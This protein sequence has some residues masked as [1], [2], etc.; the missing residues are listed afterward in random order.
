[1]FV[2]DVLKLEDA[3]V[4]TEFGYRNARVKYIS[5]CHEYVDQELSC[6]KA[7]GSGVLNLCYVAAGRLDVCYAGVAG[8]HATGPLQ[9]FFVRG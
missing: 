2:T 4:L 7:L 5:D 1:M 8:S 6:C 3:S 9:D